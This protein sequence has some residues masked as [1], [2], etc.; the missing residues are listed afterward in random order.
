MMCLARSATV[1]LD[2]PKPDIGIVLS[3][4]R[5][6]PFP[7]SSSQALEIGCCIGQLNPQVKADLHQ[8]NYQLISTHLFDDIS[9]YLNFHIYTGYMDVTD[10]DLFGFS[11]SITHTE[12]IHNLARRISS[13]HVLA[14]YK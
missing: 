5:S 14:L 11:A 3:S 7:T 6:W 4:N 8:S 12:L 10:V 2:I 13:Q 1:N 9:S